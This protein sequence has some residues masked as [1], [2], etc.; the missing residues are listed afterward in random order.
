MSDMKPFALAAGA[1]ATILLASCGSSG[2]E[3]ASEPAGSPAAPSSAAPSTSAGQSG[4]AGGIEIKDFKYS[5]TMTFK[6]GQEV[7][8][9]NDDTAAHTV[10]DPKKAFDTGN[11]AAGGTGKF[12]APDA[13]GSYPYICTYHPN[14]KG[15]LT[16]ES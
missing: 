6:P 8:V 2:P 14:M 16:V 10:T 1:A 3:T 9:T 7:S 15:T 4:A 13:A 11:V 12:T 5:G